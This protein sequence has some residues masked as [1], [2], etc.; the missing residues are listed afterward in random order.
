MRSASSTLTSRDFEW[1]LDDLL[2]R[3]APESSKGKRSPLDMRISAD[4]LIVFHLEPAAWEWAGSPEDV[5]FLK[6]K[7][8]DG[9][10]QIHNPFGRAEPIQGRNKMIAIRYN[11][12]ADFYGCHYEYNLGVVIHQMV[13]DVR[14][15]TPLIIDPDMENDHDPP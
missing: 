14:M 9:F 1:R 3:A 8:R 6:P 11:P 4:T 10:P 2:K 15:E 13:D 7:G 12:E 5:F